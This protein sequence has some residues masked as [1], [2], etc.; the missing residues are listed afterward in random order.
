M[1][2]WKHLLAK[3]A[4]RAPDLRKRLEVVKRPQS[5][6]FFR[7]VPGDVEAWEKVPRGLPDG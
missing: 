2:E 4:I 7:I 1:F 3:L 6:P 5:H